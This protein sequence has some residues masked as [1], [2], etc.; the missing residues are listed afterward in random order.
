MCDCGEAPD[1]V[2]DRA[3]G[4]V[5][6]RRCGVV[7]EAVV[8]DYGPEW[9]GEGDSGF[10]SGRFGAPARP[11]APCAGGAHLGGVSRAAKRACTAEDRLDRALMDGARLVSRMASAFRLPTT[12]VVACAAQEM[13][14]ELQRAGGVRG[15]G[16]REAA[17]AAAVYLACKLNHA[18]RDLRLASDVMGVD[19]RSLCSAADE[20]KALLGGRPSH[21]GLFEGLGSEAMLG[22]LLDR[23]VAA[24][25]LAAE[26][27]REVWAEANRLEERLR[28][29][30][31]CGR[32]PRTLTAGL[33]YV[34][35]KRRSVPL[36]R[37]HVAEACQMCQQ[38]LD[39][40]VAQIRRCLARPAAGAAT[41][42][43]PA[44]PCDVSVTDVPLPAP[45]RPRPTL[46]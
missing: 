45:K 10:G 34:A 15:E 23:L 4:A 42:P 35:A 30:L 11:W 1:E 27:R 6:C 20:Y 19:V 39:K 32:K 26:R 29:G 12:G 7:T 38:T 36:T 21:A 9:V 25:G 2:T 16:S 17:A 13:Y 41:C 40:V 33:L 5:V 3:S 31:D 24:G 18:G 8:L 44:K 28:R 14:A 37:K 22:I 43:G 46:P